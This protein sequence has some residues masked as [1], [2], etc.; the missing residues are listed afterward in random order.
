MQRKV[1][2]SVGFNETSVGRLHWESVTE[3]LFGAGCTQEDIDAFEKTV[4]ELLH[5]LPIDATEEHPAFQMGK[6][7]INMQ[8]KS[9]LETRKLQGEMETLRG[10]TSGEGFVCLQDL[11]FTDVCHL[12]GD[13]VT[14]TH[15]NESLWDR[16]PTSPTADVAPMLTESRKLRKAEENLYLRHRNEGFHT[17]V[18]GRP[19]AECPSACFGHICP[20]SP[21]CRT[22]WIPGVILNAGRKDGVLLT[23]KQAEM[24]A[25][26]TSDN[27]HVD[28]RSLMT[29]AE[30]FL[31]MENEG[32][33]DKQQ[34]LGLLPIMSWAD[35]LTWAGGPVGALVLARD[36]YALRQFG[37]LY[38]K[39]EILDPR[40][41]ED[42]RQIN[43][44]LSGLKDACA[45]LIR[46]Y[47]EEPCHHLS[48]ERK[49]CNQV[50]EYFMHA[51][52]FYGPEF[53]VG[54]LGGRKFMKI[55]FSQSLLRGDPYPATASEHPC[56][57]LVLLAHRSVNCVINHLYGLGLL[58]GLH[59]ES[60]MP[61]AV[62]SPSCL[63]LADGAKH[64]QV[65]RRYEQEN[66]FGEAYYTSDED[67]DS[68][69]S[70]FA[71]V[72]DISFDNNDELDKLKQSE[73]SFASLRET[74]V[75]SPPAQ[76]PPPSDPS[77]GQTTGQCVGPS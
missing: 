1:L 5:P 28:R 39:Y 59:Y 55:N 58:P 75:G 54:G 7:M 53:D 67:G 61:T 25:F 77:Q 45:D 37:A 44:A 22:A 56:P 32:N 29:D 46:T 10:L 23:Q 9:V 12:S 15:C 20:L 49:L 41:P 19:R 18:F 3:A 2:P 68:S 71:G 69:G 74:E 73:S 48:S 16:L 24:L 8:M 35:Q 50:R 14:I 70:S 21:I 26:G 40:D 62:L 38:G 47:R 34:N 76:A 27:G 4:S 6:K 65:C 42:C 33:S 36:V 43:L 64:C 13:P 63:D 17:D 57:N 30:N 31:L 60:S 66:L 51:K 52:T 72:A 11:A